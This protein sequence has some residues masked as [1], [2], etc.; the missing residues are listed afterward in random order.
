MCLFETVSCTSGA[1]ACPSLMFLEKS[2]FQGHSQ[3][4]QGQWEVC[5]LVNADHES[6]ALVWDDDSIGTLGALGVEWLW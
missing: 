1:L 6:P 5:P 3:V 2:D 4:S